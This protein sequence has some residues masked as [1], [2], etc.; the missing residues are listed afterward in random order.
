MVDETTISEVAG[1]LGDAC[2]PGSRVVLFGSYARGEAG[3]HSDL[4]FLVIEPEVEHA[5]AEAVRLR[6]ALGDLVVSADI[7]VVSEPTSGAMCAEAL[8]MPRSPKAAS[9]LLDG[10]PTR[11]PAG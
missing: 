10:Q 3:Q 2:P 11:P 7:I 1:C 4:D 8:S 6:R 9:W 5:A